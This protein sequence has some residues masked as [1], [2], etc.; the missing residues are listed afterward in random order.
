[1]KIT[2]GDMKV[3]ITYCGVW[4]FILRAQDVAN[5]IDEAFNNVVISLVKKGGGVF[6]ITVGNSLIFSKHIKDR[7]PE[8]GEI[9]KLI[10]EE[11]V[12]WWIQ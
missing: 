10:R 11:V 2:N 9:V 1:M 6:D 8:E 5:E 4:N 12:S 3:T 7:F